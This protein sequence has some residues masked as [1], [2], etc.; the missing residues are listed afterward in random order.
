MISEKFGRLNCFEH[1]CDVAICT[2]QDT[3]SYPIP[4]TLVL[5]FEKANVSL[6]TTN[7]SAIT[8]QTILKYLPSIIK[9]IDECRA[10]EHCGCMN[11]DKIMIEDRE[12]RISS[13]EF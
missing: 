3:L 1:T 9:L 8:P 5:Y 4:Y 10:C 6:I 11:K 12:Y 2:I 7:A 13:I